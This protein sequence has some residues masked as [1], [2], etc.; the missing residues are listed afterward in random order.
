MSEYHN[1]IVTWSICDT[2]GVCDAN[3]DQRT[4]YLHAARAEAIVANLIEHASRASYGG[5][6]RGCDFGTPYAGSQASDHTLVMSANHFQPDTDLMPYLAS[7]GWSRP[8]DVCVLHRSED[9]GKFQQVQLD[10]WIKA[11][12]A[13]SP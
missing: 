5:F 1:I 6:V 12:D 10:K 2:L 8:E 7:L 11:Q 13:P 9:G 3:T 4:A